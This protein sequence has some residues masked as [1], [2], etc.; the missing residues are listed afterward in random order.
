MEA[1]GP[2]AYL[3]VDNW[4]SWTRWPHS[5]HCDEAAYCLDDL[6]R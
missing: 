3:D 5:I 6:F 2:S 4:D 1:L